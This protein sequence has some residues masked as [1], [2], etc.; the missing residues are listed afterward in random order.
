MVKRETIKKK[1]KGEKTKE[2]IEEDV[3]A[4]SVPP[5]SNPEKYENDKDFYVDTG[6]QCCDEDD[7]LRLGKK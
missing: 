2:K 7:S 4:S 6:E 1:S 5:E 3:T